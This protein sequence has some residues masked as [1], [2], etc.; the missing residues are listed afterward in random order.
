MVELK[1]KEK[2]KRGEQKKKKELI[3]EQEKGHQ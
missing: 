3:E 1:R 2:A